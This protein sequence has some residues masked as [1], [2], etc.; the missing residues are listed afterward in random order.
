M[1]RTLAR[2][3]AMSVSLVLA[4][5]VNAQ[6]IK[7]GTIAPLNSPWHD[8][9]RDMGIEWR[10]ISGG[11]IDLKI[12][13][14]GAAGDEN[15]I[16]RKLR[17][18]QLHAASISVA[19]L[20]DIVPEVRALYLPLMFESVEELDYVLDGVRPSIEAALERRGLKVL[21]WGDA[22]WLYFFAQKPVVHPDDLRAQRLFWWEA[23]SA[24]V[25]ALKDAGFQPVP[26]AATEMHTALKTGLVNAFAAPSIA[27]LSFQWFALAPHMTDMKWAPLV[28]CNVLTTDKWRTLPNAVKPQMLEAAQN[29]GIQLR[30]KVR[31][32][33]DEAVKVMQ[34]HGLAVH[35]VPPETLAIWRTQVRAAY[36][37]IVG[38]AIPPAAVAEVERLLAEYRAKN[39]SKGS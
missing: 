13:P 21:N 10:R 3:A 17:V 19:G 2:C 37:R 12:Y 14:G 29:A 18:G 36:P 39:K 31:P 28:G 34:K 20:A 26:L 16:V 5:S 8:I 23:G 4:T 25:E 33:G 24:Y 38:K 6:T 32:L 7:L 35:K 27:A 11:K 15:D 22:G 30:Q 1:F 9:V